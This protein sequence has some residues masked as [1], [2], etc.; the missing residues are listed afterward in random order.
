MVNTRKYS[1]QLSGEEFSTLDAIV[2]RGRSGALVRKRAIV[3]L[4]LHNDDETP[5]ICQKADVSAISV[6]NIARRFCEKGF[7]ICLYGEKKKARSKSYT[8][9]D[10]A[11]LV[12]LACSDPPEGYA[13][14]TTTLLCETFASKHDKKLSR[15]VVA[16]ILK[17][18]GVNPGKAKC[19]A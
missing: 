18:K 5:L 16:L 8:T 13:K 6:T 7:E 4:G 11:D 2:R 12:A 3:L 15:S 1:V 19:G 10:E 14:W 17:K 9:K